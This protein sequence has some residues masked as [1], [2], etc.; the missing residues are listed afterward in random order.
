MKLAQNRYLWPSK[1]FDIAI[2]D[3]GSDVYEERVVY[4]AEIIQCLTNLNH[5]H[6]LHHSNK[7]KQ[8][9]DIRTVTTHRTSYPIF[10]NILD[11]TYRRSFGSTT[12]LHPTSMTGIPSC[13]EALTAFGLLTILPSSIRG[14]LFPRLSAVQTSSIPPSLVRI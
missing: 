1:R 6:F 14:S 8:K 9:K 13:D 2:L 3:L 11:T 10:R 5:S 12:A 7:T 4:L